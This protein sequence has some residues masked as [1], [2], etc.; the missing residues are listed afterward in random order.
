MREKIART[1][2]MCTFQNRKDA[3]T[4]ALGTI[5]LEMLT[6][7]NSGNESTRREKSGL[8]A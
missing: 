1:G 5:V 6:K 8:A 2:S 3:Y 4:E 7:A